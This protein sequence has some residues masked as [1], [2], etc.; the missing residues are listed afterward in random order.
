MRPPCVSCPPQRV[1]SSGGFNRTVTSLRAPPG[2]TDLTEEYKQT[3]PQHAPKEIHVLRAISTLASRLCLLP[4]CAGELC[5]PPPRLGTLVPPSGLAEKK[6][7][8]KNPDN[9]KWKK[10]ETCGTSA[11]VTCC[12]PGDGSLWTNQSAIKLRRQT[13]TPKTNNPAQKR[14]SDSVVP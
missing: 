13:K 10:R 1:T 3:L 14:H 9:K 8:G 7:G 2:D 6:L 4:A 12:K 11:V 5:S